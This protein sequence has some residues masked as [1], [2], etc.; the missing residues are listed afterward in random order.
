MGLRLNYLHASNLP[1]I[2]QIV[3]CRPPEKDGTFGS[4]VRPALVRGTRRDRTTVRSAVMVSYGTANLEYH[5]LRNADF[6]IQNYERLCQLEL[7]H[8]VRFDLGLYNWLPWC[9]EFFCAPA[10]SA[11]ILA[12]AL[13]PREIDLLR[14]KL[15]R[16]GRDTTAL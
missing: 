15:R 16:R 3:W 9:S 8:A 12:G 5:K 14:K 4:N 13:L 6:F 11:Y 7:P 2:H 10:H 1:R